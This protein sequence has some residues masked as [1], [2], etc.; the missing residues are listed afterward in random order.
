MTATCIALLRKGGR[1]SYDERGSL[2]ARVYRRVNSNNNNGGDGGWNDV[3][4]D[5]RLPDET[6]AHD[7]QTPLH[8]LLRIYLLQK[9]TEKLIQMYK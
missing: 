1:C 5:E 7:G 3:V 9:K 4:V 2:T 6:S 8:S